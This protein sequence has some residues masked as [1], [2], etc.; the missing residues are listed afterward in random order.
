MK[1]DTNQF[2]IEK[3]MKLLSKRI[4]LYFEPKSFKAKTV[5]LGYNGVIPITQNIMIKS[6]VIPIDFPFQ[7]TRL[8]LKD[9]QINQ[10]FLI[11]NME[12]EKNKQALFNFGYGQC[13]SD[14]ELIGILGN[15]EKTRISKNFKKIDN[16]DLL[17]C[18]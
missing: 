10:D 17:G 8:V 1:V 18:F 9:F 6:N 13:V 3:E 12:V 14:I 2:D 4:F 16:W 15:G 11:M 5:T 7:K